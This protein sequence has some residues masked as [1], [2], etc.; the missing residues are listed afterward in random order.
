MKTILMLLCCSFAFSLAATQPQKPLTFE[1][2]LVI[3]RPAPDSEQLTFARQSKN[4]RNATEERLNVQKKPL[5]D[6]SAIKRAVVQK[7][8]ESGAS[9]VQIILTEQGA[10][11][12]AE[13]TR[14]KRGQRLAIVINGKIH[15]APIIRSQIEKGSALMGGSFTSLEAAQLANLLN[16][17][18]NPLAKQEP[19]FKA[20]IVCF[21]GKLDSASS[22]AG[23]NFQPDGAIQTTN[24]VTCGFA[25]QVSEI[26]CTFAEQRGDKDV[27]RFTR[28][29]P[30]DTGAVSTTTN[31]VEFSDSRVVVFEDKVQAVLIEPFMK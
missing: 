29:F 20:R 13:A 30:S 28:R 16:E 25:G 22:C 12:V 8:A 18:N 7:N 19:R 5:I 26:E 6:S 3:E 11:Q 27:Y 1:M 2:R 23:V 14:N 15:S 9:E 4:A 17:A 31:T 24:K 10:M 21:N